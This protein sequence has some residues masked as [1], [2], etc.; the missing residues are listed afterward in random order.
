MM[1]DCT[2][3]ADQKESAGSPLVLLVDVCPKDDFLLGLGASAKAGDAG[4]K[5]LAFD[6]EAERKS[7]GHEGAKSIQK[8]RLGA[9]G[10]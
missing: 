9:S 2:I 10:R 5:D 6:A 3:H 8:S 7:S 4:P 1:T